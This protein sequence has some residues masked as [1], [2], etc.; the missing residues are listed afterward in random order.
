MSSPLHD[1]CIWLGQTDVSTFVKTNEWVVPLLQTL[2]ILSVAVILSSILML[3]LRILG[4]LGKDQSVQAFAVRFL[5]WIWYTIPVLAVGG[6]LQITAEPERSI[7]NTVF[8]LKMVLLLAAMGATVILGSKIR[9]PV[10]A[11]A[12][13]HG[14][15]ASLRLVS[16]AA[17][18]LWVAIIVAG[19]WIAY[20]IGV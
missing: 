11:G 16:G 8:Q 20:W 13:Q 6:V 9:A 4:I 18:V 10:D 14:G 7:E 12:A 2:H 15:T 19:R 1:F 3:T 17:F 5:P